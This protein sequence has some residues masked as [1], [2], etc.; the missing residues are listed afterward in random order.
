SAA[1]LCWLRASARAFKYRDSR[2][3][4]SPAA[5][6]SRARSR[7]AEK[8][9]AAHHVPETG[10]PARMDADG[11]EQTIHKVTAMQRPRWK[12]AIANIDTTWNYHGAKVAILRT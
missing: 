6:S 5:R 3:G 4:Q 2:A 10:D 9:F 8:S 7:I 1:V 12:K 11:R